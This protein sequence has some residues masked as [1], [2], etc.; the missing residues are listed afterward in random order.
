[1]KTMA[2]IHPELSSEGSFSS[3]RLHNPMH[4]MINRPTATSQTSFQ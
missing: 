2:V 4:T 1:M 3:A